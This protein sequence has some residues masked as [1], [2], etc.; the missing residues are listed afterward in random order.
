MRGLTLALILS[1]VGISCGAQQRSYVGP[2]RVTG[3]CSGA[4][5]HYVHCKSNDSDALYDACVAEC[6]GIFI[7]DG[8]RDRGSLRGLER[9]SC[10]E[11]VSFVEGKN[12]HEPDGAREPPQ[13]VST[14][15][16]R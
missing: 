15:A 13:T 5:Q 12:G 2:E 3:T 10:V 8:V 16:S 6:R 9:L 14:E 7:D 1:F 11:M 4:C